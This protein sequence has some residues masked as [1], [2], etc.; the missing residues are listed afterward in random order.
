MIGNGRFVSIGIAFPDSDL[1]KFG[2]TSQIQ[3]GDN[4][5]MLTNDFLF[6]APLLKTGL[7]LFAR[8]IRD[9]ESN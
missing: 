9:E 7:D 8:S 2:L 1:D 3:W 6:A 4:N 5:W